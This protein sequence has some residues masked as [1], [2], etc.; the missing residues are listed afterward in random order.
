[1]GT[2]DIKDRH[3]LVEDDQT[4]LITTHHAH[5]LI[6]GDLLSLITIVIIIT[7]TYKTPGEPL[8]MGG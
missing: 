2:R 7:I 4:A 1:M 3:M 6:D 8:I 5:Q